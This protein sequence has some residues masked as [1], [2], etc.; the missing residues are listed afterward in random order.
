VDAIFGGWQSSGVFR[1]SSGLP[2]SLGPG[3]GFWPTNWELTGFVVPKGKALPKT[4]VFDNGGTPNVFQDSAGVPDFFRFAYP[5]ETGNRNILRGPG[6]FNIDLGLAKN[7]NITE[8]QRLQFRWEVFNITNSVRFDALSMSFYNG[9][10]TNS[11]VGNFLAPTN[12]VP[13]VMQFALRYQ[14]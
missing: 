7:W 3:L 14:F 8:S 5:G 9:S 1:W 6:I 10:I 12:S 13:R 2:F 11:G 4:G